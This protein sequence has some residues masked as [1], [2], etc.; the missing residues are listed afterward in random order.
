MADILFKLLDLALRGLISKRRERIKLGKDFGAIKRK[1]TY[2][3]I[4]NHLPVALCELREF[5][6]ENDLAEHKNIREFFAKWLN[7]PFVMQ[8][9][10][11]AGLYSHDQILSLKDELQNIKL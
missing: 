9:I 4:S 5:F 6:I 1:I 7:N 11:V 8:G 10:P 3:G 2:T